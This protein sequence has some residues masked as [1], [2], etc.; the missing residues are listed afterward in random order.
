M[1]RS[2]PLKNVK[3][4]VEKRD[5]SHSLLGFLRTLGVSLWDPTHLLSDNGG[6]FT[7]KLFQNVCA[8]PGI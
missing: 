3:Y 6:Q 4:P 1:L 7:A 8:I 2:I 5:G